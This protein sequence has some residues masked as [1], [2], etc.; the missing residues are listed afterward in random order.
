M[1]LSKGVNSYVTLADAEAYFVD[2]LDVAA[3]TEAT[4]PEKEKALVTATAVL[5]ELLWTG[6]AVIASQPLAWPRLGS[7]Y[8]PKVGTMIALDNTVPTRIINA[9][10]EQAYHLLNN[11][12]LFDDVGGAKSIDLYDISLTNITKAS[13]LSLIVDRLTRPLLVNSGAS[14][15]WRA[16]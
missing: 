5:D 12:G 8:D 7:Y 4:D 13:K 16:N 1:A 3:W 9:T 10:Y 15:W 11:D 2:R 14:L 6:I